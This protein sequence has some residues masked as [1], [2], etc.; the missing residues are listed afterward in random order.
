MSKE[1]NSSYVMKEETIHSESQKNNQMEHNSGEILKSF[2]H[3]VS[4]LDAMIKKVNTFDNNSIKNTDTVNILNTLLQKSG[5]GG[6]NGGTKDKA[7]FTKHDEQIVLVLNTVVDG[8]EVDSFGD[9]QTILKLADNALTKNP[10]DL[11]TSPE[12]K[13]MG[14][15]EKIQRANRRFSMYEQQIQEMSSSYRENINDF[16][17]AADATVDFFGGESGKEIYEGNIHSIQKNIEED[18]KNLLVSFTGKELSVDEKKKLDFYGK[19]VENLL[20]KKLEDVQSFTGYLIT[21][22]KL[23]S[24]KNAAYAIKGMAEGAF[25]AFTGTVVFLFLYSTKPEIRDVVHSSIGSFYDYLK[26]NH[27][28]YE[29]LWMDFLQAFDKEFSKLSNLPADQQAEAIGKIAGNIMATIIGA[30]GMSALVKSGKLRLKFKVPEANIPKNTISSIGEV[31]NWADLEGFI[32]TVDHV[33]FREG[34]TGKALQEIID[35]VRLGTRNIKDIPN[36]G[37]IRKIVDKLKRNGGVMPEAEGLDKF[38]QKTTQTTKKGMEKVGNNIPFK[39]ARKFLHEKILTGYD[40]IDVNITKLRTLTGD[41]MSSGAR[42]VAK[43]THAKEI[44]ELIDSTL[45][46]IKSVS[47]PGKE[48]LIDNLISLRFSFSQIK[49]DIGD[50]LDSIDKTLTK[51]GNLTKKE[52]QAL[53]FEEGL[54]VR[55]IEKDGKILYEYRDA[56]G[57]KVLD[58]DTI[59]RK[60]IPREYTYASHFKDGKA[61]V[62]KVVDGKEVNCIINRN[63]DIIS[64]QI[65][66]S[67]GSIQ[68][69][70]NGGYRTFNGE[71]YQIKSPKSNGKNKE[72]HYYTFMTEIQC[73]MVVGVDK[74]QG[75]KYIINQEG[76]RFKAPFYYVDDFTEDG[77]AAIKETPNG[78]W[79]LIDKKGNILRKDGSIIREN[80]D[81]IYKNKDG[82]LVDGKGNIR[83]QK[84]KE[85]QE[86]EFHTEGYRDNLSAI[87]AHT[88]ELY[89]MNS[90]EIMKK[91]EAN[92]ITLLKKNNIDVTN[93]AF[94]HTK[95]KGLLLFEDISGG[96]RIINMEKGTVSKE[97][98]SYIHTPDINN[99]FIRVSP[100]NNPERMGVI[101]LKGE[102]IL[103]PKY[104]DVQIHDDKKKL[105]KVFEMRDIGEKLK[106]GTII[107]RHF[108][109]PEGVQ[110][111]KRI[112]LADGRGNAIIETGYTEIAQSNDI[113]AQGF[114]RSENHQILNESKKHNIEKYSATTT[115]VASS[116]DETIAMITTLAVEGPMLSEK[117]GKGSLDI[118]RSE[119]STTLLELRNNELSLLIDGIL[120]VN[121]VSSSQIRNFL[122][123]K[124]STIKDIGILESEV[125]KIVHEESKETIRRYL[126]KNGLQKLTKKERDVVANYEIESK[127]RIMREI[128]SQVQNEQ[129]INRNRKLDGKENFMNALVANIDS[130]LYKNL[131]GGADAFSN[132]TKMT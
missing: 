20:G 15:N 70:E 94:S 19:R 37:G 3:N 111:V 124:I 120:E 132:A 129:M 2:H 81:I 50:T 17:M 69:F 99:G 24:I 26:E 131:G 57:K 89:K 121:K 79:L 65:E 101:D 97:A 96:T 126:E 93:A 107:K 6:N 10:L 74:A 103:E 33:R 8:R 38:I 64:G 104:V 115:N 78:K 85:I 55:E 29:K 88:D 14:I 46:S 31:K 116:N 47:F 40:V 28:N 86:M 68:R 44:K 100:L 105:F 67:F 76:K 87:K 34:L 77:V 62:V 35:E 63:G 80:K 18:Y 41:S 75:I 112:G 108:S 60:K 113:M 122:K 58:K 125:S 32:N 91:I 127:E 98:F 11:K 4:H 118:L 48:A 82:K 22:K 30:K 27:S 73:N 1:Q 102:Y 25:E 61:A 117:A 9:I 45:E 21:E 5:L 53:R 114:V 130:E 59:D 54:A 23:D 95:Q 72:S 42:G 109:D 71:Y 83:S 43:I 92:A 36:Y 128:R 49:S 16:L 56:K 39:E 12:K 13:E 123:R 106:D 66:A 84:E 90:P 119:T 52:F 110:R 7:Y 51:K